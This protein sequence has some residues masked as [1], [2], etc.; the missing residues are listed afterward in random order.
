M[1]KGVNSK[2]KESDSI[3]REEKMTE[4]LACPVPVFV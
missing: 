4:T 2:E 1:E 3:K